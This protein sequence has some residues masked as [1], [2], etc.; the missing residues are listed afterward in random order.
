AYLDE[1]TIDEGNSDS[2]VATQRVL[3]GQSLGT[4]DFVPP[5]SQ[6]RKLSA[7]HSD[8]LQLVP[9]GGTRYIALNTKVAPLDDLNVRN[10]TLAVCDRN[11]MRLT[12]GGA[13]AG[14]VA[15]G[16]LPPGLPGFDQAG[17]LQQGSGAFDFL[18]SPTGNLQLAES[19]M[20]K[21]GY[22]S[23]KYTGSAN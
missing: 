7:A 12:F 2:S 17:G 14:P 13:I 4:G 3:D 19:Y 9:T 11:A 10:A 5:A 1:I 21:A 20:R 8:E 18:R 22:A 16:F 23:G 6:L 15:S